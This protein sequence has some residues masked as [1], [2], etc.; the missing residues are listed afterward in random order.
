MSIKWKKFI[1]RSLISIVG[2]TFIS[3]GAALSES[4]AMGLDPFTA[5]NRG[6]S[7]LLG[8]SLGNYQLAVNLLSLTIIFFLKRSLIGWGSVY[9]MILIG[10]QIDFFNQL[11]RHFFQIE[12]LSLFIRIMITVIAILIF[13]LGVA[14]YMDIHLGVSPYDAI[15]PLI[16]DRTGWNYT[17]VRISQD[18]LVVTS[19]FLLG[20]PVGVSTVITG[21]FAGPLI[22]MF[23]DKISK[24]AIDQIPFAK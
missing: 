1:I 18:I 7:S 2:I 14:I 11:F 9:N 6:V 23:S 10:Y 4:M 3:F 15:A 21:F 13:S 19:A 12:N 16:V 5:M 17:P 22:E 20:G 8:V 24:R